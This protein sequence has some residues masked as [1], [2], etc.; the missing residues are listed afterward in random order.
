MAPSLAMLAIGVMQA[1]HFGYLGE[2]KYEAVSDSPVK[3]MSRATD[4]IN[5]FQAET[6]DEWILLGVMLILLLLVVTDG[7]ARTV[8]EAGEDP[9]RRRVRVPLAFVTFVGLAFASPFWVKHPFNWWMINQRFLLFAACV[10]VFFP[11]GPIRGARLGLVAAA[12]VVMALLPRETMKQYRDFSKRAWPLVNLIRQTP[13]GSNTLVLLEPGRSLEDP[14][15]APRMTI[16]RELYNYPL[17]Y[18]G[19]YDPY[20]YDD[21]FPI[22]RIGSL[23]APKVQRAAELLF[24]QEDARFNPSTMMQ[25]WDYFIVPEESRDIMPADGAV[26][27]RDA[28][29][30]SLYKNVTR[31]TV[32]RSR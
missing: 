10:A 13:M 2:G 32:D 17:V 11:R 16:W 6:S 19:G 30:W 23:P 21:G 26:H 3:L 27:I 9:W 5:L 24:S 8:P 29:S 1:R 14:T 7:G 4:M 25:G 28:G 22:R 18:R 31:P 15:V 20:L 12:V